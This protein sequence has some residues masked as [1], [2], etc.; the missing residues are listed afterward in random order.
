MKAKLL[1]LKMQW[2]KQG[3][4]AGL[5]EPGRSSLGRS[6]T[7]VP[8]SHERNTIKVGAAEFKHLRLGSEGWRKVL[9]LQSWN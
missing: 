4:T 8:R 7:L 1:D 6:I 3:S 9:G 5:V 2:R